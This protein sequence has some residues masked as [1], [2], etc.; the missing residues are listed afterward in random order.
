MS[1]ERFLLPI[2]ILW[3]CFI[4]CYSKL[5]KGPLSNFV[6]EALPHKEIAYPTYFG[7]IDNEDHG[8]QS[9]LTNVIDF[10]PTISR[11]RRLDNVGGSQSAIKVV[12]VDDFGAKGDGTTDDT[13][14]PINV[15]I[16]KTKERSYS[17]SIYHYM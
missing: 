7:T 6:D 12:N 15:K 14:V 3:F 9:A 8:S 2:P 10:S 1:V 13:K 17:C 4:S 11:F 5:L 16:V